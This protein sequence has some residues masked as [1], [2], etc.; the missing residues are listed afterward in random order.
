MNLTTADHM[1]TTPP[2]ATGQRWRQARGLEFLGPVQ[3]SGLKDPT[4]LVRRVDD[5][6]VQLSELL[7]LVVRAVEPPRPAEQV[8]DDVSAAYGRTLSVDGLAHLVTTRLEPLGLVVPDESPEPTR[9]VRARPAAGADREGHA[10]AGPD[11]R[12]AGPR[13]GAGL[14]AAAGGAGARRARRRRR[15][16]GD[17]GR[18]LGGDRRAVRHPDDRPADLRHAHGRG[19]RPR[20]RARGRLPLRRRDARARSA[21]GSTSSS[22]PSTPT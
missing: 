20:A 19:P 13:P 7:H 1:T 3:G 22:P 6:V 9:S 4:F 10:G 21:S 17:A 18:L 14:L 15:R 16:P 5:Q 8:A 2:P 12:P 11:R